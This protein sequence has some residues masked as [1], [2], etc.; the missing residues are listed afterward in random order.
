MKSA[1]EV[2]GDLLFA[3][4]LLNTVYNGHDPFN[5]L[6]KNITLSEALEGD[7]ALIDSS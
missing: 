2:F 3:E 6:V 7:E 1:L 4:L 5:I